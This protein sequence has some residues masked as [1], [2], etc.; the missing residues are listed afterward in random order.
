MGRQSS[1]LTSFARTHCLR[2][3]PPVEDAWNWQLQG[4]CLG[5][6]LDVFFPEDTLRSDLRRHEEAAKQICRRCPVLTQ[7][8]EHALSTPEQH[9]VWGA[10]TPT[11]RARQRLERKPHRTRGRLAIR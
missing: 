9:G 1:Y 7:C 11:E 6:P 2:L 4:S 10:M 3:P 5:Y 8:R